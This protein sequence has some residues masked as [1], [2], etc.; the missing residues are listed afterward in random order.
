MS[1]FKIFKPKD[2]SL[3]QILAQAI[4]AIVSIDEAN[5]ITFFNKAAE[6]L[7]GYTESEVMG[8]NVKMLVPRAIQ[9]KHDE[10]VNANR[11]TGED[12][13]VGQSRDVLVET[14]SGKEIWC[15]LSLSKVKVEKGT[16]YTAFVKDISAQKESQEIIDQTLEQCI[17]A[18]VTI[19]DKNEVIFFNAAAEK[20][21]GTTRDQVLGNNVKMLVPIEIQANHD[22]LV[23][24]NRTSGVDKIVGTS[25]DVQI[26]TLDGREIWG[27]LSLSKVRLADKILYTAFV[28]DITEEKRQKEAFA[29]L[30]LVANETDNSVI[31]TDSQ[32][33]IEYVNPGFTKL[34]GWQLHDVMGKR[35][36]S[37]LQGEHTDQETVERI[38]TNLRNKKAF[39]DE[40]LNYDKQ[41]N[42][43]WISLAI[44]PVFKDG[45]L[46]KF[47]SIQT[48]IDST[49]RK[50]I[51]NDVRLSAINSSNI[52]L[53]FDPLGNLIQANN[54]ALK[55]LGYEDIGQ[56]RAKVSKLNELLGAD[57]WAKIKNGQFIYQ[58][59]S[60]INNTS[61]DKVMLSASLSPVYNAGKELEKI[62]LYAT[63]VS[64]RNKVLGSTHQAMSEVMERIASIIQ[65]INNISNQTNLLALNAAI[66]SARAG[67]AGRGFAVVADEVRNLA[68]STT[69]SADEIGQL[70]VQTEQHVDNLAKHL[71]NGK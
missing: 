49:K 39:Y 12:K 61:H 42:P 1:M 34:T 17:D 51:E 31:I 36:G 63:N 68:Q 32:G 52:A 48:N 57:D 23:N 65:T 62:L 18:V 47:I 28:K 43:Y 25:R 11:R 6:Q 26:Q 16:I 41:G 15:N 44:N 53:E 7:W 40:I 20:L 45:K 21:W 58:D 8:K 9:S 64:A 3:R 59:L 27:N 13:I 56:M 71:G 5:C 33:A 2:D 54:L 46:D 19:N 37:V 67:E 55:E 4:D 10:F 70:I 22:N 30:S 69:Q 50:T 29:T 35:P 38:G 66:E 24:Q 14:K 60:I